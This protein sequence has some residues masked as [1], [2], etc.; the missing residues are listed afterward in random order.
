VHA[1]RARSEVACVSP[2]SE[3]LSSANIVAYVKQIPHEPTQ[4]P[5]DFCARWMYATARVMH[6]L[7]RGHAL[8]RRAR[9]WVATHS[10]SAER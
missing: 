10:M 4:P 7:P 2:T 3:R 5:C 8:S 9:K 6:R 1:R